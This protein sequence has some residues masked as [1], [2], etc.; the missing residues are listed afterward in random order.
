MGIL[1]TERF[2][3]FHIIYTQSLYSLDIL[4]SWSGFVK[5][6]SGPRMSNLFMF[7]G[8][9]ANRRFDTLGDF[10]SS[11]SFS[12]LTQFVRMTHAYFFL[13]LFLK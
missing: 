10:F 8:S 1:Y 11:S 3:A 4:G 6:M 2:G 9:Q 13:R 7:K 12:D 5:K